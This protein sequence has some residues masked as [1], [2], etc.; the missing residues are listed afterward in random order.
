M[1]RLNYLVP[2]LLC[3]LLAAGFMSTAWGGQLVAMTLLPVKSESKPLAGAG[4]R[5]WIKNS[6]DNTA[7]LQFDLSRLAKVIKPDQLRHCTLRLVAAGVRGSQ[8]V[9]VNGR[10][11]KDDFS[12][13]A[14]P[15]SIVA[16]SALSESNRIAIN[17]MDKS[18]TQQVSMRLKDK[19]S[20]R[21]FSGSHKGDVEFYGPGAVDPSNVPRLVIEYEASQQTF[22]ETL[23]WPQ[24]QHDPEH[25]GFTPWRP[26]QQ[27]TGFSQAT[28]DM[29]DGWKIA[30][31]PL[32]YQGNLYLILDK[33]GKKYMT[34]LNFKGER[35][36]RRYLGDGTVQRSPAIS[37]S[38]IFYVLWENTLAGYDLGRLKR[39][40]L[41]NPEDGGPTKADY[42]TPMQSKESSGSVSSLKAADYTDLTVGNDG[43]L[44]LAV[45]QADNN[46]ILAFTPD[47]QAFLK[48]GPFGAG[49][50]RISPV[51]VSADGLTLFTQT[52]NG[53]V[54]IDIR[55][56]HPSIGKITAPP[57]DAVVL[58]ADDAYFHTPVA[59]P[60]IS[61][62]SD[63]SF[64]IFA[65]Y[66]G[67]DQKG[68][69]WG[70][71]ADSGSVWNTGS[72]NSLPSQ[73]VLGGTGKLFF[74]L[75][76][77]LKSKAYNQ[78][79]QADTVPLGEAGLKTTSNLVIDGSGNLYFW[80]NGAMW[81]VKTEEKLNNKT[82][83]KPLEGMEKFQ[84]LTLGADGVI[85]ANNNN[86][87]QLYTIM[88]FYATDKRVMQE[89]IKPQT[90]YRA[91]RSLRAFEITLTSGTD[92]LFQAGDSIALGYGFKV[93]KGA[94]LLC[95]TGFPK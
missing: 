55:N 60:I 78:I 81:G 23:A 10:L 80:D 77:N 38:G 51:S 53:A 94:G 15:A 82:F 14:S 72:N 9:L 40:A 90:Y 87:Q 49:K 93:E 42:S 27:P 44:F 85:W 18:L 84:R 31:F 50:T 41:L 63:T 65:N 66:S 4:N 58:A 92:V 95:R 17:S 35:L 52:P 69:V 59:I 3:C 62:K 61:G 2:A 48:A 26:L 33:S 83:N 37:R 46:Y 89:D 20:L 79:G 88:P 54:A 24:H 5:L 19:I 74:I 13:E 25:T 28:I 45:K 57:A 64:M 91:S 12:G 73:P 86:G 47:L 67:S 7:Y 29:G 21:L 22:L 30:S 36:W 68:N 56:P 70:V 32:Q 16:L 75:D 71:S 8:K 1:P 11:A 6:P 76:G 39:E 34:A 43:S